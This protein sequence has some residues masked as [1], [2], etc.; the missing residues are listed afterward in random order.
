VKFDRCAQTPC[1]YR[2]LV[3]YYI[4]FGRS[5]QIEKKKHPQLGDI[6]LMKSHSKGTDGYRMLDIINLP[7]DLQKK[8]TRSYE[9]KGNYVCSVM[10]DR[11]AL[12][13]TIM[14]LMM[15]C[16]FHYISIH[17][18]EKQTKLYEMFQKHPNYSSL[19]EWMT[20][21][22][23][24][25]CFYNASTHQLYCSKLMARFP[26][27]RSGPS[28]WNVLYALCDHKYISEGLNFFLDKLP[29]YN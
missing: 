29:Q 20:L 19:P 25:N 9:Q 1:I 15:G 27:D 11:C 2:N 12:A 8:Y 16:T 10:F 5:K 22:D 3:F 23:E 18:H 21:H 14:Q 4:D 7:R 6:G 24:K 13:L 28:I 26:Y 17:H